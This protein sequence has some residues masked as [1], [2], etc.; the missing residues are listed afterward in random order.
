MHDGIET[1]VC[2]ETP[3]QLT[4]PDVA[5]D[6]GEAGRSGN[7]TANFGDICPLPARII[8]GVQIVQ[9]DDLITA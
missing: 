2:E 6:N 8:V 1:V 9:D 4:I 3:N 5:F 7:A